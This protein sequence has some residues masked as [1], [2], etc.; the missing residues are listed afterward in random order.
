MYIGLKIIEHTFKSKIKRK[1]MKTCHMK[2]K[3]M[4]KEF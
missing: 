2:G 4:T 3:G 1:E